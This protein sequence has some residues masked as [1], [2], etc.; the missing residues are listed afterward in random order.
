MMHRMNPHLP[1]LLVV[2]GLPFAVGADVKSEHAPYPAVGTIQ[3][4]DPALD[5]LIAPGTRCEKLAE[6]FQWSEG[7]IWIHDGG[8]L[9]FSDVIANT[10]YRWK[11]GEG[12]SV[13]LKPSGFLGSNF[14][15]KEPGSNGL[16]VDARGRLILC[17]HG[18]R[19]VA[20]MD[21]PTAS[22]Q[23]K[24]IPIATHYQGKRLN[25]PNDV[26][27]AS[28]GSIYFTDPPYGL[29]NQGINDPAKQ[30]DFQGVYRVSPT[31]ELTAIIKDLTRPNGLALSPDEKTL[32]INVSDPEIPVIMAYDLANGQASN[33]RKFFD[34]KPL[35]DQKLPGL[36][37]GMKIDKRGNLWTTGPG[38]VL[39]IDSKGKQLGHILTGTNTANCN[40]GD[41]G[42]TL[43]MTVNHELWRIKTR[44][45]GATW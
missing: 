13:Y 31:G 9:V 28:D 3:R 40:W 21:A 29:V 20:R 44:T 32:Y 2:L 10:A 24:F 4:L 18:E 1:A 15:G 23:S 43:Y 39:I 35:L 30:L 36:P 37:D 12:V 22:P 26:I 5:Q 45:R 11:D 25:S 27:V 41:D 38:G 8:F 17:Q 7:P 6:G 42:S 33:P 19:Q 14:K 34:T 16:T